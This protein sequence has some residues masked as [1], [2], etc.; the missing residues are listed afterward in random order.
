MGKDITVRDH[1]TGQALARYTTR[2]GGVRPEMAKKV[3]LAEEVMKVLAGEEGVDAETYTA[4]LGL[5][6][7]KK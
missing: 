2:T 6:A 3:S 5:E 7:D 4:A 1:F